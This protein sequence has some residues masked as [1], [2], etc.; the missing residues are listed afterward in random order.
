[1]DFDIQSSRKSCKRLVASYDPVARHDNGERIFAHR[2]AHWSRRARSP[3]AARDVGIGHR[4]T[5]GYVAKRLPYGFLKCRA[6]PIELDGERF[7]FAGKVGCQL[8][9]RLGQD[10]VTR[11]LLSLLRSTMHK[12]DGNEASLC[13]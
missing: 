3:D 4:V 5:V 7:Q 1:M 12:A 11:G 9:L 8:S 6:A 13:C 2:S 10:A